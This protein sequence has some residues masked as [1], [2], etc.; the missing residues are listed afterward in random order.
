MQT[1]PVRNWLKFFLQFSVPALFLILITLFFPLEEMFSFSFD[2]GLNLMKAS[3]VDEGYQL[4]SEIW[5]DQPPVFTWML[6]SLFKIFGKDVLVA[7]SLVLLFSLILI[8]SAYRFIEKVWGSGPALFAALG[9][10]FLPRYFLLS[11]SVMIGLPAIALALLGLVFILDWHENRSYWKLVF[12]A[13]LL[14]LSVMIKFFTG[15]IPL[16]IVTGLLIGELKEFREKKNWFRLIKPSFIWGIVFL[17]VFLFIAFFGVGLDNFLQLISPHIAAS[18]S[19]I[20]NSQEYSL[21][22]NLREYWLLILVSFVGAIYAYREKKPQ[23]GYLFAW[24][25]IAFVSLLNHSP[26]WDHH[27]IIITIPAV[28][29]ISIIVYDL[30]ESS[31]QMLKSHSNRGFNDLLRVGAFVGIFFMIFSLRLP[32]TIR[33]LSPFSNLA[34]ENFSLRPNEQKV[35]NRLERYAPSVDWIVTDLPMYAFQAGL[36]TPPEIAV[37]SEKRFATD[38]AVEEVL[39]AVIEQY[40]PE[41]ILFGRRQYEDLEVKISE[42]YRL[43]LSDDIFRLYLSREI[44]G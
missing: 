33:L 5:S 24:I 2:E 31:L 29:M 12:S 26:V 13:I 27:L 42:D 39:D 11:M 32:E 1:K 25:W 23:M 38:H 28:M 40:Q 3:L 16:M 30:F 22:W 4:Y 15:F 37:L 36:V 7:R 44:R 8:W 9:I 34:V 17:A 20:F 10:I 21:I 43:I 19:E 14:A 35:M 41:M 18:Q 6:S